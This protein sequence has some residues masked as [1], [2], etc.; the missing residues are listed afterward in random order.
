[1]RAGLRLKDTNRD[2]VIKGLLAAVM[3]ISAGCATGPP[4][5]EPIVPEP[6]VPAVTWGLVEQEILRA[7]VTARADAASWTGT[8]IDHWMER[9]RLHSEQTFIPWYTSY[10]TQEWLAFKVA[11]SGPEAAAVSK[12]AEYLQEKFASQVLAP[13]SQEI[14][15]SGI[16]RRGT[17]LYAEALTAKI[18]AIGQRHRL[19]EQAYR[20]R[21]KQIP[22]I[23]AEGG[24]APGASLRCLV[25]SGDPG[26]LPPYAALVAQT[27][28]EGFD[29]HSQL[30][31]GRLS[32]M[33][34][35]VA[36]TFVGKMA[37]RGGAAAAAAVLG[38]PA[39]FVVSLGVTGFGIAEHDQHKPELEMQLRGV[40]T[41]ALQQLQY[42]LRDD[43]EHGVLG[44]VNHIHRHIEEALQTPPA[45]GAAPHQRPAYQDRLH[46]ARDYDHPGYEKPADIE[47][48]YN[49]PW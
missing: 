8:E 31:A 36:E 30:G 21:L 1:M 16:L 20:N 25:E 15:P 37:A 4:P 39:G 19:P 38:G 23:S 47:P 27:A 6:A 26:R 13:A 42:R 35:A 45:A 18:K 46:E 34:S 10:W 29:P 14:G 49:D 11:I 22:A 12:L 24:L 7:A 9:V 43:P 5:P 3:L 32:P 40:L 48:S 33:A 2:R 44:A 28:V 41:P 17:K